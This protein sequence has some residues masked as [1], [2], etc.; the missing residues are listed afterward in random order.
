MQPLEHR[1]IIET[2]RRAP[3]GTHTLLWA[4]LFICAALV[5]AIISE[6]WTRSGV[7]A[8][9]QATSAR[10]AAL[11]HDVAATRHAI[12][13]AQSPAEIERAARRWGY[14]RPGD[15]SVVVVTT[16]PDALP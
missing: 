11:R 6:A 2:G 15:H 1:R 10:N 5:V 16:S 14:I 8:Q 13:L 3:L 12:Q 7:E 9:A 4:L